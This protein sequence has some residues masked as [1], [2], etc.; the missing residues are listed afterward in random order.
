MMSFAYDIIDPCDL[1]GIPAKYGLIHNS[2]VKNVPPSF[3]ILYIYK[4]NIL[5]FYCETDIEQNLRFV[6]HSRKLYLILI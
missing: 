2:N 1:L 3:P 5:S 6:P 4:K